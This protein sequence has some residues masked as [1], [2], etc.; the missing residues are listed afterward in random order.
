VGFLLLALY[1]YNGL[2]A[3]RLSLYNVWFHFARYSAR[4]GCAPCSSSA[5][6]APGKKATVPIYM[7]WVRP[8]Q[9]S[10]PRPTSTEVETPLDHGLVLYPNLNLKIQ[11]RL[12]S[13]LR[14]FALMSC[15]VYPE[16]LFVAFGWCACF[17]RCACHVLWNSFILLCVW[18]RLGAR[19]IIFCQWCSSIQP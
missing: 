3:P 16:T 17:P 18:Q 1:N 2:V 4:S 15:H 14:W 5:H 19:S 6:R 8:G 10:N 11:F 7:V 13:Q 9:E 12:K